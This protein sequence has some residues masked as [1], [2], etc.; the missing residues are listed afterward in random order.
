MNNKKISFGVIAIIFLTAC[1]INEGAKKSD[2]GNIVTLNQEFENG[3]TLKAE[4]LENPTKDKASYKIE[5]LQ[6][7]SEEAAAELSFSCDLLKREDGKLTEI[8]N[9]AMEIKKAKKPFEVECKLI[10]EGLIN[11]PMVEYEIFL[12]EK[13]ADAKSVVL[14]IIAE[15]DG[16]IRLSI[17]TMVNIDEASHQEYMEFFGFE[18]DG[19]K[20]YTR[21]ADLE[22]PDKYEFLQET[23]IDA[24]SNGQISL[25]IKEQ[26]N[27]PYSLKG[28]TQSNKD[29]TDLLAKKHLWELSLSDAKEN[30]EIAKIDLEST[31]TYS[32]DFK[33]VNASTSSKIISQKDDYKI[34]VNKICSKGNGAIKSMEVFEV[35]VAAPNVNYKSLIYLF[36][37]ADGKASFAKAD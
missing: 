33:S 18:K 21:N 7:N 20:S 29:V 23:A 6:N 13:N 37:N 16:K 28:K 27:S 14:T 34:T 17:P 9:S 12:K 25:K 3:I 22:N 30:F 1:S 15:A 10:P 35:T 36:F 24:P 5:V 32:K 19:E 8:S 31:I 4:Q 2:L 26:E 11:L